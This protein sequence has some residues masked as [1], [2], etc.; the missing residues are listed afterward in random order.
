MIEKQL[1]SRDLTDTNVLEAMSA[2]DREIFVPDGMK[3]HA[4]EDSPLPIGKGQTISQPYMVAYM[5]QELDLKPD[6]TVLEIGTGCGYNAAVFAHIVKHVYSIEI[7]EWLADFAKKNLANAGVEN[8]TVKYDDGYNGWPEHA[9]FDKIVLTAA[10]PIIPDAIKE[11][12]AIGGR[13]VGPLSDTVQKLIM[14]EKH[15]END[16]DE[17]ELSYVSFVPMTG[18]VRK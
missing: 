14:L 8:V 9:P 12:M 7:I 2:I 18:A 11:Q 13:L 5:A 15:G 3:R 17:V 10:A 4:Y 6:D 16:F 1:K